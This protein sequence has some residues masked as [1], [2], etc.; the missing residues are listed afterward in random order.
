LASRAFFS[1]HVSRDRDFRDFDNP[2]EA[3]RRFRTLFARARRKRPAGVVPGRETASEIV[4]RFPP[5]FRA[6]S[7]TIRKVGGSRSVFRPHRPCLTSRG[8]AAGSFPSSGRGADDDTI[9]FFPSRDRV[10]RDSSGTR[11]VSVRFPRLRAWPRSR[12][13]R[14][15][16]GDLSRFRGERPWTFWKK[17]SPWSRVFESARADGGVFPR[18]P[19]NPTRMPPDPRGKGQ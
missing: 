14:P 5:R 9:P 1:A 16:K 17:M 19:S 2:R 8:P 15:G 11:R 12:F 6:V 4:S 18:N 7:V 10:V 3:M 13:P